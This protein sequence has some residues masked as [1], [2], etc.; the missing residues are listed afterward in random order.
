MTSA[1]SLY[2]QSQLPPFGQPILQELEMK[3]CSIDPGADAMKLLD[4]Q[5]KE[6]IIDFGFKIK[7]LRRVKIKIFN[8]RGFQHA[9]IAIPYISRIKGTKL[10]DINAYI[11]YQDAAGRVTTEKVEKN[12]I[13][14]NNQDNAFKKISF[15]FPNLKAGC[16]IEYQYEQTEKNSLHLDPWLFQDIIPTQLSLFKLTIPYNIRVENRLMGVDS[17]NVNTKEVGGGAFYAP[18]L[19]R[20]YALHHVP[21]FKSE[22]MMTSVADNLQRVEFSVQAN[23]PDS[24]LLINGES[25]WHRYARLL[26]N[27]EE[28]GKQ[29]NKTIPGTEAV[30][31]SAR[32]MKSREAKIN[33]L[34]Q[35]VKKQV[36]WDEMQTFYPGSLTDAWKEKIG[37]SAE[38]NLIL[39]NL[40]RQ[41]GI[42]SFPV[43]ISTRENGR[44]DES[45][46]SLSQFNGVDILIKDSSKTYLLDG[47]QQFQSYQI[48][49]ANILNRYVLSLDTSNVNWFLVTD[50]R[51]LL[52]TILYINAALSEDGR[53]NGSA[54][55][56]YFDHSKVQKLLE[57]DKT[58]VE[59]KAEEKEFIKKDFTELKIDSLVVSDKD[60]ELAPLM[61]SFVFTHEPSSS[62]DFIFLDP[63]FL[64]SFRKN[65]F[66]DSAR[67]FSIDFNSRQYLLTS[68]SITLPASYQIDFQ[69]KNVKL[70]MA[71]SSIIFTRTI[72]V[73]DNTIY[74][75]NITEVMEPLF[76]PEQY[77]A[78]RDF[79]T[80]MYT[81][82]AEQ[83][84]LKK[85]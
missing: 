80:R 14:R 22:K 76:D 12:Q 47:T 71:D 31:D 20:E 69:P 34:C 83:I 79:F 5:E 70:R 65:P 48:P 10:S 1:I 60:D 29:L 68:M 45:F 57:S 64:S 46:F 41:S 78:I 15:T 58:K 33:Y 7:T 75:T 73:V 9:N 21:A 82:V 38:I 25:R 4:Y 66:T 40:L 27:S 63:F 3:T 85:K 26:I 56:S 43:L 77:P 30:I 50:S 17:I 39:L 54:N 81:M 44:A 32:K 6:I 62:G 11:H 74:F 13:F 61:E 18:S 51:P 49:P 19:A 36:K 23:L 72:R 2:G 24:E 37:N 67:R 16:V 42:A 28:F 53:I 55:I 84:V 8:P 35:Q 59:E 52:K